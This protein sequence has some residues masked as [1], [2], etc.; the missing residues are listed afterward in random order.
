MGWGIVIVLAAAAVVLSTG[1]VSI[2]LAMGWRTGHARSASPVANLK[3]MVTLVERIRDEMGDLSRLAQK[4]PS[5]DRAIAASIARLTSSLDEL[6]R[7]VGNVPAM[8][9]AAVQTA[10]LSHPM[11]TRAVGNVRILEW[12]NRPTI[13]RSLPEESRRYPFAVPQPLAPRQSEELPDPGDFKLVQCHDLCPTQ[14][15][16]VI[17]DRPKD[18]EVVIGLGLPK[19]VKFLL[20]RI[21]DFRSVYM[22]GQVGFLVTATFVE[23]LD[24]YRNDVDFCQQQELAS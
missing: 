8:A 21:D 12:F 11:G 22:Y 13:G 23:T 20:A 7:S 10:E 17:D 2:G 24:A 16:Y 3:P 15:R 19:P 4:L 18:E 9:S 6:L 5:L 1:H 14:L